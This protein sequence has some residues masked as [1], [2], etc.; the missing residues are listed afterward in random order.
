MANIDEL[1]VLNPL[2]Y[3]LNPLIYVRNGLT[4]TQM[5]YRVYKNRELNKDKEIERN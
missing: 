5:Y 4:L 3:H 2:I 1:N